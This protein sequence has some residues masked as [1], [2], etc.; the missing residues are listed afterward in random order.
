MVKAIHRLPAISRFET[1]EIV[2]VTVRGNS[3]NK[4]IEIGLILDLTI[5]YGSI[6]G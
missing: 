1:E 4:L 5:N 2:K 6:G 3:I